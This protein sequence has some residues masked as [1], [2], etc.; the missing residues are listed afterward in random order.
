MT[1]GRRLVKKSKRNLVEI[2]IQNTKGRLIEKYLIKRNWLRKIHVYY[3]T[4]TKKDFSEKV[5]K[6]IY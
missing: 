5:L 2:R 4:Y 6:N 1:Y 3:N